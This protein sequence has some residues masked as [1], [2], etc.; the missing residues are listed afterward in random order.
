[1]N[2]EQLNKTIKDEIIKQASM[3][4]QFDAVMKLYDAASMM[5]NPQLMEQ[6]RNN[7]HA[8]LDERLDLQGSI[9]ELT[10]R[11]IRAES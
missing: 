5:P 11:L 10:R 7:L 1:M 4:H 9:M 3:Q 8:L 6:Q 2:R